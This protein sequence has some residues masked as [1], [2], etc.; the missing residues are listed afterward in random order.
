MGCAIQLV[1]FDLMNLEHNTIELSTDKK[2]EGTKNTTYT[3][4]T[5]QLVKTDS[6]ET[7][8]AT[9]ITGLNSNLAVLVI[10]FK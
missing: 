8:I 9:P 3:S 7:L 1:S 2:V 10:K 5:H 6:T 4:L